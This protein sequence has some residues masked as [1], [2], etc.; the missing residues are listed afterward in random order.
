MHYEI[1]ISHNGSHL[2]AT[3]E[4]SIKGSHELNRVFKAL[5]EKFPESEGYKLSISYNPAISYGTSRTTL[6]EVISQNRLSEFVSNN[7]SL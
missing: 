6:R 7:F 2:F 5:D 1:N 3:A 4:R